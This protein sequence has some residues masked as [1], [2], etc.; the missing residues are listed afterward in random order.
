MNPVKHQT[1]ASYGGS[2]RTNQRVQVDKL[3]S[4]LL[5]ILTYAHILF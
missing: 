1:T 2:A 4:R 5:E 3:E